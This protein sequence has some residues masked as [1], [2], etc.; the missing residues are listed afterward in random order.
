MRSRF[1]CPLRDGLSD[2]ARS[3]RH[4]HDEADPTCAARWLFDL[5][6]TLHD[7]S[8]ASMPGLHVSFGEYIQQHLRL[9]AEQSDALR[10]TYW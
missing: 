4:K 2:P 1:R 5:D 8:S 10:R 3:S 9:T 7:A 6:D